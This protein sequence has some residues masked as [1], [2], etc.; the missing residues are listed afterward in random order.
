M[1]CIRSSGSEWWWLRGWKMS[2]VGFPQEHALRHTAGLGTYM[3]M[4]QSQLGDIVMEMV[5]D[6][7]IDKTVYEEANKK[8]VWKSESVT[9]QPAYQFLMSKLGQLAALISI[10]RSLLLHSTSLAM[11]KMTLRNSHIDDKH[12]F[13]IFWRDQFPSKIEEQ[14]ELSQEWPDCVSSSGIYKI[15]LTNDLLLLTTPQQPRQICSETQILNR[16]L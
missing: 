5:V 7:M 11:Q 8:A 6:Q 2:S 10:Y 13:W 12:P 16:Q 15:R 9:N 1:R 3:Y 4:T 14:S